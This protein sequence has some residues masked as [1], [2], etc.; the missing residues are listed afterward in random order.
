MEPDMDKL[1]Q[2]LIK[3]EDATFGPEELQLIIKNVSESTSLGLLGKSEESILNTMKLLNTISYL[4]EGEIR[5]LI[6][7]AWMHSIFTFSDKIATENVHDWITTFNHLHDLYKDCYGFTDGSGTTKTIGRVDLSCHL[8]QCAPSEIKKDK[9]SVELVKKLNEFHNYTTRVHINDHTSD[10]FLNA[11]YHF[12]PDRPESGM[13]NVFVPQVVQNFL[14][15]IK[16]YTH[17][18]DDFFQMLNHLLRGKKKYNEKIIVTGNNGNTAGYIK[19]LATLLF[20]ATLSKD[21]VVFRKD[22]V[23]EKPRSFSTEGFFSTSLSYESVEEFNRSQRNRILRITIPKGTKFL[24]TIGIDRKEREITL[25]PGTTLEKA[26]SCTV[27]KYDRKHTHMFCEYNVTE[28]KELSDE[29]KKELFL[30]VIRSI[31]DSRCDDYIFPYDFQDMRNILKGVVD[32][33]RS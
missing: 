9:Y 8:R 23:M 6:G 16:R 11:Y 18:D 13:W 19:V 33:L 5:Y 17:K 14:V 1:E 31:W 15:Q 32:N 7:D 12:F 10:K 25:M 3:E 29:S 21:I 30:F 4:K 22:T 28:T 26:E 2:I 24:P 20:P 27:N